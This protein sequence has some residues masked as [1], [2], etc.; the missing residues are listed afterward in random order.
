MN[1]KLSVAV[2]LVAGLAGGLLTRYITPPPVFAQ[3]PAAQIPAAEPAAQTPITNEIRARSFTLV[4]QFDETIGTFTVEPPAHA[5]LWVQPNGSPDRP[6]MN[7]RHGGPM[8][9]VLRDAS[10]HEIWSAG[11]NGI[12]PASA[13]LK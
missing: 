5:G 12:R 8:R 9:V 3:A 10:G 2:A 4:D 1:N 7:T 6:G 11:G 13:S